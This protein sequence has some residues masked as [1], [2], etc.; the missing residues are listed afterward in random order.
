[1]RQL[2]CGLWPGLSSW[3]DYAL[4]RILRASRLLRWA[5]V[6]CL[7]WLIAIPAV[8]VRAWRVT[9]QHVTPIIHISLL[10]FLQARSLERS[11]VM[12]SE[13]GQMNQAR[14]AWRAAIA[15]HPGHLPTLRQYLAF[16]IHTPPQESTARDTLEYGKWLLQLNPGKQDEA[17]L[18]AE[19]CYVQGLYLEA[20]ETLLPFQTSLGDA[21]R[22]LLLKVSMLARRI[23]FCDELMANPEFFPTKK[24]DCFN[25]LHLAYQVIRGSLNT[26]QDPPQMWH[27]QF[28][29]AAHQVL[30]HQLHLLISEFQGLPQSYRAS[31]D[32]LQSMGR[33]HVADHLRYWE[34]LCRLGRYQ[35]ATHSMEVFG[36]DPRSIGETLWYV[37]I[38]QDLGLEEVA[39]RLLRAQ[40]PLYPRS[41]LLWIRLAQELEQAGRWDAMR[42]EALGV[43]EASRHLT[44]LKDLSYYMEARAAHADQRYQTADQYVRL[45]EHDLTPW[46][47]MAVLIGKGLCRM[48]HAAKALNLI[49]PGLKQA[50]A[51]NDPAL[52]SLVLHAR[53][54]MG[55]RIGLVAA[56]SQL[57]RINPQN[58]Y[59]RD[60]YIALLLSERREPNKVLLMTH[61][62]INPSNRC[63]PRGALHHAR[64]LM[65]NHRFE[66]AGRYLEGLDPTQLNRTD[67]EAYYLA[68]FEHALGRQDFAMARQEAT[69]IT[70][71]LLWP[72]DAAFLASALSTLNAKAS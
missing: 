48:G 56:A 42:R 21:A 36:E 43:R 63:L 15:N 23:D 13:A 12:A 5:L 37:Q 71:P 27:T 14:H 60:Q 3:D 33:D 45:L 17:V 19:A 16:L 55:S 57:H 49:E 70:A 4:V 61:A 10:D 51:R 18:F 6:T 64:A 20:L 41:P 68:R 58:T 24:D 39:L 30:A 67:R 59:F 72:G 44:A 47:S 1:M 11:A 9:P 69:R 34:L 53:C 28:E 52:W 22:G 50:S 8:M 29:Q 54:T 66:E 62:V 26:T 25:L 65:L 40:A 35:E 2:A 46:P 32:Y 31:L 38:A 7:A